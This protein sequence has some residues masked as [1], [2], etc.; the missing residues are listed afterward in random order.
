MDSISN[1]WM[2]KRNAFKDKRNERRAL[3]KVYDILHHPNVYLLH[4]I[5]QNKKE[6]VKPLSYFIQTLQ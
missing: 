5:M 2:C 4:I 6:A 1:L 3:K